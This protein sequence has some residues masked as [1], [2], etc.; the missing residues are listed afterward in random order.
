MY[1]QG[2][3]LTWRKCQAGKAETKANNK[4]E[5][6]LQ[7]QFQEQKNTT[8]NNVKHLVYILTER[9]EDTVLMEDKNKM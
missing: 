3:F 1:S 7:R 2:F 6:R 9:K 4:K 5:L 8:T